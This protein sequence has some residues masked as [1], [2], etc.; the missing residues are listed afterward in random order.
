MVTAVA[1][2]PDD[3]RVVSGSGDKTVKIWDVESGGFVV[4]NVRAY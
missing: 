4:Y 2:F 3:K 1:V